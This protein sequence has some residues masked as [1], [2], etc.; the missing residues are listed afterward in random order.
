MN[1]LG[2]IHTALLEIV[3]VYRF[4]LLCHECLIML[5]VW[6]AHRNVCAVSPHLAM[7][8]VVLPQASVHVTGEK[9]NSGTEMGE[10]RQ[11]P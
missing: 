5:G 6:V 1:P 3:C 11:F 4:P 2:E 7:D 10:S 8:S 9:D